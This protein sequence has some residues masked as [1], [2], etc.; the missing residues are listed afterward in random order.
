[1]SDNGGNGDLLS[2]SRSPQTVKLAGV[3]RLNHIPLYIVGG[4]LLI[5]V[6]LIVWTASERGKT[7]VQKDLDHGGSA[8]DFAVAVAGDKVGYV[9]PARSGPTPTP[10]PAALTTSETGPAAAPAPNEEAE[11]RKKAFFEA[12]FAKSAVSDPTIQQVSNAHQQAISAADAAKAVSADPNN[13]GGLTPAEIAAYERQVGDIQRGLNGNNGPVSPP[14]PN[15]LNNYNGFKDRWKL[16]TRLE[17]PTTPYILRTGSVIPGLLLSAMESEL[18]G[19]IIAQV[20]QDVYDTPTGNYLL[21]PQGSRLIGEYSNAV[22]YGQARIFVAWQRIIYP[23]GSALDIGA[24]PGTDEEGEAGFRDQVDNHFVRLF[25]SALLMSAITGGITISQPQNDPYSSQISTG[26]TLGA[27]LGQQLGSA[28]S[29]L[30]ERNLSIAPTLKIRP[31][32]R[33]NILAIKDLTFDHP[34]VVGNF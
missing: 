33:F 34:Y 20:S 27:A 32:Y 15:N 16:N 14:D 26:Q 21:I 12:L 18:P 19:S 10:P 8:Q 6:L 13:L 3:R 28:T 7:A 30:L 2:A 31:G 1:M 29:A 22:Q 9:P 24:M 11:A 5:V 25:G 23:D 4:I 17:P